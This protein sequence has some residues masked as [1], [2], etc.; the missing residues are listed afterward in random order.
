MHLYDP[1]RPAESYDALFRD[2][3][4]LMEAHGGRREMWITEWGVYADDDPP[5]FPHSFGDETMNRCRWP[6]ERTAAEHIVKFTA[7]SFSHGV[8]KLFLHAGEAGTINGPDAGGILFEYGGTPRTMYAAVAALARILGVPES[9]AGTVHRD[10]RHA[11]A[12]RIREGRQV[13]VAW[14]NRPR[15]LRLPAGASIQVLDM[16]GNPI[17]SPEIELTE[18]PVYFIGDSGAVLD[19]LGR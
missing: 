15:A 10:G 8:R 4:A 9:S 19:A 12:F 6:D 16:M 1:P 17:P 18:T 5:S 13:T 14:S 2:L 7:V 3:D 11:C